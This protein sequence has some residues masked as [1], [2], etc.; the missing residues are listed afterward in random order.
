MTED[1]EL[2]KEICKKYECIYG[3]DLMKIAKHIG[4]AINIKDFLAI[5]YLMDHLSIIQRKAY[6]T[7]DKAL[8]GPYISNQN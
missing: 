1:D 7:L 4:D 2:K 8:R 5:R 6:E 3:E